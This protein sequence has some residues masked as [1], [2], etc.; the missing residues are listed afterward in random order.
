MVD[1]Q[2]ELA[3]PPVD[4]LQVG[5]VGSD[6]LPDRPAGGQQVGDRVGA[7]PLGGGVGAVV[8]T[9]GQLGGDVELV[10]PLARLTQ[11]LG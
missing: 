8:D 4:L 3:D 7:D 1:G 5:Q 9:P 6:E 10:W 11:A 2:V